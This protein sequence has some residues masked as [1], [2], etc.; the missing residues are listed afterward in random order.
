MQINSD[1][2]VEIKVT[3]EFHFRKCLKCCAVT[4]SIKSLSAHPPIFL[5]A[6]VL[7][8]RDVTSFINFFAVYLFDKWVF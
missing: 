8:Y 4:V 2:H 1:K 5:L 7:Y 6:N 3:H